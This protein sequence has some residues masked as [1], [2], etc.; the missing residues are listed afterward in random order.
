MGHWARTTGTRIA[1]L[2]VMAGVAVFACL[3]GSASAAK[4]HVYSHSFGTGLSLTSQSGIAVDEETGEVY[5]A[6]TQHSRVAKFTGAGNA[7]GTL[8]TTTSEPTFIAIDNSSGPSKGDIYVVE[9]EKTVTK[10]TP[11]GTLVTNWGTGG[12]LTFSEEVIGVAVDPNGRPWVLTQNLGEPDPRGPAFGFIGVT[13]TGAELDQS[14]TPLRSWG[15]LSLSSLKANGLERIAR[16]GIAVDST[17]NLYFYQGHR[18]EELGGTSINLIDKVSP[19][20]E[21]LPKLS[22]NGNGLVSDPSNDDLYLG[23]HESSPMV[24]RFPSKF[25][26]H[27]NRTEALETFGGDFEGPIQRPGSAKDGLESIASI[28]VT[29]DG[30][31]YVL[32][33]GVKIKE[34]KVAVFE[35][36]EVEPPTATIGPP[37]SITQ[38][39]AHLVGHIDPNAPLGSWPSHD[40]AWTFKCVPRCPAYEGFGSEGGGYFQADGQEHTVEATLEGL[41]AG[42]EYSVSLVAK[43]RG[44]QVE[45]VKESFPT[46]PLAPGVTDEYAADVHNS[47]ATLKAAVNP[48]GAETTYH[49]EYVTKAAFE[50][51]GFGGP[52]THVAPESEPIAPLKPDPENPEAV[53]SVPQVFE[54]VKGLEPDTD[55][56]Y[57]AVA[58]NSV[59][60]TDGD[61]SFFRSQVGEHTVDTNCSNQAL[62]THAGARLPD[63]RAYELVSPVEKGGSLVEPFEAWLQASPDGSSATWYT[64]AAATG[65]PNTGEGGHQDVGFYL[66]S[67]AAGSW[68]SQ[69][70]LPPESFGE[71]GSF[72]GLSTDGHY[73]VLAGSERG[74]GSPGL[75][76]LD[77]ADRSLATIV[78]P[79]VGQRVEGR[80]FTLDGSSEDDSLFFFESP[81]QLT[82]NAAAGKDN[83]YVWNR[84]SEALSLAGVLPGAKAEAPAGGSFGGSYAWFGEEAARLDKGGSQ[85]GFYVGA[86]HAISSNGDRAY[87]TAGGT[88]QIYLRS[89]LTGAKPATVRVSVANAGVNDPKGQKPAALLEATPEGEKV[90]FTSPGK[91]T[92]DASTGSS[93]EGND[94]YRYDA[95]AKKLVDVTPLPGGGAGARVQGLLGIAEDGDSGYLAA[96]GVL[97][98]GGVAGQNNVYHF[99]EGPAGTFSFKFVAAL[100]GD[101]SNWSPSAG[102]TAG[103]GVSFDAPKTAR[104]SADGKTLLFVSRQQLDGG[105]SGKCVNSICP[106]AYRYSMAEEALACVSCNPSTAAGAPVMGADLSIPSSPTLV[107]E[108]YPFYGTMPRNLSP[109]GTRVFFQTSES[110]LPEDVNGQNCINP[111]HCADVYEWEAVGTG[112]CQAAEAN[113]G[114]IYLLSSGESGESSYFLDA[115]T[116]GDSA[117][118][119]SASQLVPADKDELTDVYDARVD[120]GLASQHVLASESCRS[121]EACAGQGSTPP[122]LQSAGTQ[123]FQGPGNP[124]ATRCKQGSARKHARC[125]KKHKAKKHR[126]KKSRATGKKHSGGAK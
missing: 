78:P 18:S 115:S 20:G 106:E 95:V 17:D 6:D 120:G 14:G 121:V 116:N 55:Y 22:E 77:T 10:L 64:G 76:L 103:S 25:D 101:T 62:R 100:S 91:L 94:L 89:G 52:Q 96:K 61:P 109:A 44:G 69:R 107:P 118:F 3:G 29:K 23:K 126:K 79:Q 60:R 82:S 90:F 54:R 30:S 102:G 53:P 1:T 34:G 85:A 8:A 47:E 84:Q 68:S 40:V 19:T 33:P 49:F 4:V 39:S 71:R 87:F 65:V 66:S 12:H 75:Y 122:P 58:T 37:D 26:D 114:C 117:F 99:E 119:I 72:L 41:K 123:S 110:L 28:A 63:C 46:A 15:P 98:V 73:A 83:F 21:L 51:E 88:G 104:V 31:V 38:T 111:Y 86:L 35:L 56:V 50:A 113:G 24:V 92:A 59:G 81:L 57:R 5:I 74:G 124:P 11:A 67:L 2:L 93:D 105:P 45:S 42:W 27:G 97:A 32:D 108:S 43:N 70:L 112:T 9:G 16:A 125:V 13:V 80:A 36:E 48:N 7:D